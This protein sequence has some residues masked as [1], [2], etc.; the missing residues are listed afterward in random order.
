M[1][2]LICRCCRQPV[3]ALTVSGVCDDCTRDALLAEIEDRYP[4][5]RFDG[6]ET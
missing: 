1:D 6:D 4:D 3:D 2:A 5:C